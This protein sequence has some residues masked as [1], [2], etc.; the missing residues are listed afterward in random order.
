VIDIEQYTLQNETFRTA[1]WTGSLMQMT[2]M[3][4]QPGEDI[5]LELHTTID[6]FL[7]VEQGSGIMMMGDT[8]ENLDFQ[9]R[10]EDDFAIFIPAGKWHNLL[11]D[12]DEPLKLYSI[13]AP[14][15]HPHGTVH[16]TREEGIEHDHDH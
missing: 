16:E 9:E 3:T 15:E 13:Y 14:V 11:N 2:V 6:Q 4:L 1:V 5:G 10:V 8:E 7:R 12:S